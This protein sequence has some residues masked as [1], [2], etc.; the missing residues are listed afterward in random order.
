MLT[1]VVLFVLFSGILL[2][3]ILSILWSFYESRFEKM[4]LMGFIGYGYG[5]Q[6]ARTG[7]ILTH[8]AVNWMMDFS[9]TI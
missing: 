6:V 8:W 1:T 5:M 9:N 2:R 4:S 3:I 7:T